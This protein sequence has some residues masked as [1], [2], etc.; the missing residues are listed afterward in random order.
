MCKDGSDHNHIISLHNLK[1]DI[2]DVMCRDCI[3]CVVLVYPIYLALTLP[4]LH[5]VYVDF[6]TVFLKKKMKKK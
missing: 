1:K 6:D 2:Y 3:T 5:I 4:S